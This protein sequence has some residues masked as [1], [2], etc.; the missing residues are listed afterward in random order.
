MASR[1]LTSLR[2]STGTHLV[3]AVAVATKKTA[4]WI[5]HWTSTSNDDPET[6][7]EMRLFIWSLIWLNGGLMLLLAAL[8]YPKR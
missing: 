6:W 4:C 7:F 3:A 5:L 2:P 1:Y 8:A